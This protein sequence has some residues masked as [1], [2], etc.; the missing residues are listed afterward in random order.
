M[1]KSK[2]FIGIY[3]L[4]LMVA[5]VVL[6]VKTKNYQKPQPLPVLTESQ[7]LEPFHVLVVTDTTEIEIRSGVRDSAVFEYTKGQS[8]QRNLQVRNDTLFVGKTTPKMKLVVRNLTSLVASGKAKAICRIVK[9]CSFANHFSVLASDSAQIH[10]N[11]LTVVTSWGEEQLIQFDGSR[12]KTLT[13]NAS[14]G[15]RITI[16]PNAENVSIHANGGEVT[17]DI[18]AALDNTKVLKSNV[19][20]QNYGKITG[21]LSRLGDLTLTKDSTSYIN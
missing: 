5:T 11:M 7:P 16:N 19:V 4:L 8:F 20:L 14:S 15:G 12:F 9:P 6:F 2:L 17:I 21:E 13:L 3:G 18:Q 1:K 10:F